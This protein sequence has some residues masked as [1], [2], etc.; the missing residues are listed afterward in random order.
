MSCTRKGIR[1]SKPSKRRSGST[2]GSGVWVMDMTAARTANHTRVGTAAQRQELPRTE[3]A[4]KGAALNRGHHA[5]G[6]GRTPR[7]RRTDKRA[8]AWE[9]LRLSHVSRRE[10]LVIGICRA[11]QWRVG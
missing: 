2:M 10:G 3:W 7:R 1:F 5:Q 8:D 4:K 9:I 6:G 11:R